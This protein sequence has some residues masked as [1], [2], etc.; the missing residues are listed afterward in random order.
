MGVILAPL[1]LVFGISFGIERMRPATAQIMFWVFSG[2]MGMSL[3]SI[4]LV[5]TH[6]SIVRVFF[7]TAASFGALSLYGYTT[8]R[9]LRAWALS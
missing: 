4:F 3:G 1:G 5:C 8:K 2:L 6:T 9:D 7:I